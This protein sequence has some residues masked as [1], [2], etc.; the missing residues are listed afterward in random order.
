MP[1]TRQQRITYTTWPTQAARPWVDTYQ[2]SRPTAPCPV[3]AATEWHFAGSGWCCGVCH[4]R[5]QKKQHTGQSADAA[6]KQ[7]GS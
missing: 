3:C 7:E 6:D 1:S 2:A 4:P 5:P